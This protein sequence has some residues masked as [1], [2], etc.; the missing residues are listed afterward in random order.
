MQIITTKPGQSVMDVA[1]AHGLSIHHDSPTPGRSVE[2][3]QAWAREQGLPEPDAVVQ[4]RF[5]EGFAAYRGGTYRIEIRDG[6][7]W[8]PAP[9][10]ASGWDLEEARR[11]VAA[12]LVGLDGSPIDPDDVRIVAET[13]APARKLVDDL[14][15]TVGIARTAARLGTRVEY[16]GRDRDGILHVEGIARVERLTASDREEIEAGMSIAREW[17]V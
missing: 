16:G 5:G 9:G 3:V 2:G 11:A 17:A 15:R 6:G 7:R 8:V 10:D 12:G 13:D 14:G 1:A 4:V